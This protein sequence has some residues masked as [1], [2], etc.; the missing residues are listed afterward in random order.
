MQTL[1]P[2][3]PVLSLVFLLVDN[4]PTGQIVYGHSY[5]Q[6]FRSYTNT[7]TYIHKQKQEKTLWCNA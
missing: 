7:Q 1:F 3:T 4:A 6:T 5:E 2:N